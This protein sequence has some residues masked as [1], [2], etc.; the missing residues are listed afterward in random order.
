[1][2]D[3]ESTCIEN[4]GLICATC[5]LFRLYRCNKIANKNRWQ[6]LLLLRDVFRGLR[7]ICLRQSRKGTDFQAMV[8]SLALEKKKV[9]ATPTK[10]NDCA[11]IEPGIIAYADLVFRGE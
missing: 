9:T 8:E 3:L 5:G 2:Q 11:A 10:K 4:T 6:S 7:K 1:M